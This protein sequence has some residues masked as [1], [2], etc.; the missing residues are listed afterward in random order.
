MKNHAALILERRPRQP[1]SALAKAL[2][3]AAALA[4][5]MGIGRFAFTPVLPMM[6]Q[7]A[8][9]SLASGGWLASAN[10]LGYL[11]GALSA[12]RLPVPPERAIR[13]GL[14]V[15]ALVTLAMGG[16]DSFVLWLVLRLLAGVAS[17]WVLI[18]VS[19][20][21]ME[22]LALYQRPF[23]NSLVFA[24]VGGGIAAAGL[25]CIGLT[26]WQAGSARAWTALGL[27]A[28]GVTALVW[29]FFARHDGAVTSAA[30]QPAAPAAFVWT[31]DALRL[32][33]C[34]GV[35][36]FGYI[37]PAT[38]LPVMARDALQGSAAFAWS[39]PVF[40]MAAA[41]STLAV[42][43]L[44]RRWG[45]RRVWCFSHLVMAAGIVLPLWS[46]GLPGILAAALGVGGTF[47]VITL[48]ALQEARRVAGPGARMLMAAM[49][50]AFAAGQ[51]AGPLTVGAA[52]GAG[53]FA[54]GLL[55]AAALLA[56]SALLLR[57]A[58]QN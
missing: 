58:P 23:L 45:N 40:G 18:S 54:T 36:G 19:A 38:F 49:T 46:G 17:A 22:A 11:I 20:W 33:L 35:F 44:V 4:V 39:W 26:Q 16:V 27:L 42:A 6:L 28:L 48:A 7:D 31:A 55:L 57:R 2:A 41:L 13:V 52:A 47:M 56:A 29:R 37:I 25:L 50:S 34:Y 43:T 51:I 1:A 10:Y 9:L 14:A 8:G 30:A 32:V 3:G 5:A 21:C 12:M 15:I 24:G 53:G